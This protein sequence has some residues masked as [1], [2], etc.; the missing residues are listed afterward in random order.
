MGK[1]YIY[2][3]YKNNEFIGTAKTIKDAA[4]IAEISIYS[5]RYIC[6]GFSFT[7]DNIFKIERIAR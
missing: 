5:V 6:E 2:R 3:I 7:Y 4:E 1:R